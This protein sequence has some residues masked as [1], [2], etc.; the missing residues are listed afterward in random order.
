M[1]GPLSWGPHDKVYTKLLVPRGNFELK[2]YYV[3]VTLPLWASV[4][5]CKM[6]VIIP[7][8]QFDCEAEDD[9][10]ECAL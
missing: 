6:G 7:A 4:F 1:V 10:R 2:T 9:D 3:W 8:S 5:L